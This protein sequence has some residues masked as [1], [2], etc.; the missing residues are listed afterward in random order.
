MLILP[1]NQTDWFL[2]VKCCRIRPGLEGEWDQWALTSTQLLISREI[3]TSPS[4]HPSLPPPPFFCSRHKSRSRSMHMHLLIFTP[5][6]ICV[7]PSIESPS[8]M[9]TVAVS[10]S[11]ASPL[12]ILASSALPQSYFWEF[13]SIGSPSFLHSRSPDRGWVFSVATTALQCKALYL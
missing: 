6:Y 13:P 10:H 1:A 5:C 11:H 8:A 7:Q 9:I 4:L 3:D 2:A 12:L